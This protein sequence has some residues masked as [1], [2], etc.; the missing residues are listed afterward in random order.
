MRRLIVLL[1]LMGGIGACS[2]DPVPSTSI[3]GRCYRPQGGANIDT[4]CPSGQA[5]LFLNPSNVCAPRCTSNAGCPQTNCCNAIE[6]L[7]GALQS[8]GACVTPTGGDRSL[9]TGPSVPATTLPGE[10][11]GSYTITRTSDLPPREGDVSEVRGFGVTLRRTTSYTL[12][13]EADG[14][15]PLEARYGVTG[16][17][18]LP[19]SGCTSRTLLLGA[20][21]VVTSGSATLAGG[22]LTLNVNFQYTTADGADHGTLAW[23]YTGTRQ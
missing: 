15:C 6:G 19:S 12:A 2:D 9:C 23:G 13:I 1:A 21:L 14:G 4:P 17:T 8:F 7:F 5:C 3:A 16:T 10:Y 18:F 20:R 11:V 22:Q